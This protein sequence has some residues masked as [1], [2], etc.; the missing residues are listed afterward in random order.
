MS[1]EIKNELTTIEENGNVFEVH[2]AVKAYSSLV[3]KTQ[4]EKVAFFNAVNAP[5]DRLKSAVNMTLEVKDIYA[6]QCQFVNKETGEV[7][8]GI[9][10]VF[11][12]ADGKS[13]QSASQ[14]V[15]TSTQKLLSIMGEPSTWKKP[16]KIIPYEIS[17]GANRNVLVF[18]IG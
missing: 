1:E 16:V 13:Y 8:N 15:F 9:R 7:T 18:K 14:G 11:I 5:T 2:N 17:K 6:E 4:E 10:I 3:P 12:T